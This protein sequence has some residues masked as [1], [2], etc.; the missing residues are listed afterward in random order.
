MNSL[1]IFD[2]ALDI[3]DPNGMKVMIDIHSLP[4]DA[5]GHNHPVWYTDE[6]T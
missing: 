5:M 1:E 3:C 6:F 4:T 2:Y